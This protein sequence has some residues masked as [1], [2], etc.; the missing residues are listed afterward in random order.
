MRATYFQYHFG[1]VPGDTGKGA[2]PKLET[3]GTITVVTPPN[4]AKSVNKSRY[5]FPPPPLTH[6]AARDWVAMLQAAASP[7]P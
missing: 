7:K 3:R 4:T 5:Q 6:P 2:G 1:E